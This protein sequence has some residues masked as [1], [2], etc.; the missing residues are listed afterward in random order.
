MKKFISLF[1]AILITMCCLGGFVQ[2][3]A[4]DGD[5]SG[6]KIKLDGEMKTL[7]AY[8]IKGNNYFKLRDI[9]NLL[10]GTEAQFDV[11]WNESVRSIELLSNTPYSTNEELTSEVLKNPVAQSSYVSIYKDGARI[12]LGAYNIADNNYFK[13]RDVAAAF[14]FG[15]D[16]DAEAQVI[17]INTSKGYEHPA[18]SG[19]GLNTMYLSFIGNTK[20]E[21]DKK[22]GSGRYDKEWGITIYDNNVSYGWNSIGESSPDDSYAAVC[23]YITLDKLFYNC[24]ETLTK[25]Q[26]KGLFNSSVEEYNQMDE[27]SVLLVNYCGVAITFYPDY[28][29]TKSNTA[30]VNVSNPF[31]NANVETIQIINSAQTPDEPTENTSAY[32]DY[33]VAHDEEFWSINQNWMDDRDYYCLADVDHDGQQEMIVRIGC[34]VAVYKNNNGNVEQVFYDSLPDSSGS[35]QY[36]VARYD[37]KDYI[38]YTSASSSEYTTLNVLKNGKLEKFR[39]SLNIMFTEFLINNKN[40]IQAEYDSYVNSIEYMSGIP[41]SGLK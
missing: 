3:S 14:D 8:N 17:V 23:A 36:W 39:E 26:I 16:W 29:L 37:N 5:A 22:L 19:F 24:P 31:F 34:G 15:V 32:Y 11:K 6:V 12:L 25:D 28:G 35:V 9:A 20:G 38:I 2:A 27:E 18:G 40:V 33:A 13:L 7:V 4:A 10:K 41:T 30:F 1:M 21:I